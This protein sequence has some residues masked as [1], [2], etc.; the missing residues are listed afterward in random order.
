[1]LSYAEHGKFP[2]T[3]QGQEPSRARRKGFYCTDPA[4]ILGHIPPSKWIMGAEP[5]QWSIAAAASQTM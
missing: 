4:R 1:M 5:A 2:A 3:T